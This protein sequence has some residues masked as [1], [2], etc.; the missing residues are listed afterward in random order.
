M[1][2]D[3]IAK[4][5]WYMPKGSALQDKQGGFQ[6]PDGADQDCKEKKP[7]ALDALD[8]DRADDI[9]HYAQCFK[10]L[11]LGWDFANTVSAF[12]AIFAGDD[13]YVWRAYRFIH[14]AEDSVV[15]MAVMIDT[16]DECK[17]LR[18]QLR[19]LL[20]VDGVD[21]DYVSEQL[22][23]DR[24]VVVAY[25]KLFFN[26]IDRKK[27]HAFIASIVY[28]NGRL[29]EGYEGYI[30]NQEINTLLMRA[31]YTHG[32]EHVL[33]AAGLSLHHPYASNTAMDGAI[34]LDARFMAD[35]L[36]YGSMGW[37]HQSAMP[38]TNARLSMQASKMGGDSALNNANIID[39]GDSIRNELTTLSEAKAKA[40]ARAQALDIEVAQVQDNG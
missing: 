32:A 17:T 27:D 8:K 1:D 28:P 22:S 19:A 5:A 15:R 24:D 30:A 18:G 33:Y 3:T 11:H 40:H 20:V 37:Q 6:V 10:N 13:L 25:E 2:R 38:I 39:L 16:T 12:P 21:H 31:G 29:E 36:F 7:T 4:M 34:E 14:G 9:V 23:I 26:V 35:G